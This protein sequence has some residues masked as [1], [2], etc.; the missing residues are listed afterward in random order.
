MESHDRT[1]VLLVRHGHVPGIEPATFRGR[2]DFQLTDQGL[3]EAQRTGKWIADRWRPTI[4]YTSPQQRCID[5][6]HA[7]AT[8]CHAETKVLPYLDDLDYGQWQSKTHEAAAAEF[9]SVFRRWKTEPQLVRFPGGE[10]LQDLLTRAADAVRVAIERHP[11]QT[12]VMVSHDSLNRAMLMHLLDQPLSTYWKLEQAPCA[13]NVLTLLPDGA[14][15][16]GINQTDH[17]KAAG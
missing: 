1:I 3:A 9:P 16:N 14:Q 10:S 8:P 13:V 11:S 5:T 12:I 7:I 4:V 6:G 2:A 15:I 17:L